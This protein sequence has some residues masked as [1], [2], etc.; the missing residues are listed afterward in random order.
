MTL[1][2]PPQFGQMNIAAVDEDIAN[3]EFNALRND[4]LKASNE[5][6]AGAR[7]AEGQFEVG[8]FLEEIGTGYLE[9]LE[10]DPNAY[11]DSMSMLM[12]EFKSRGIPT[13]RMPAAGTSTKQLKKDFVKM[14]E[15]GRIAQAG[16]K[17]KQPV[18]YTQ[19]VKGVNAETG[20]TEWHR[21]DST[22]ALNPT[23]I[24]VPESDP[25]VSVVNEAEGA[26]MTAEQ[27]ALARTRVAAFDEINKASITAGETMSTIETMRNIDFEGGP[28][29]DL[30]N[31]FRKFMMAIGGSDLVD[32]DKVVNADAFTA[33]AFD[34]FLRIMA[35]QKGPQTDNDFRRIQ[36]TFAD[37][38]DPKLLR[39]FLLDS[40]YAHAARKQEM[41]QF[42]HDILERDGTLK[43]ADREWSAYKQVTPLLSDTIRDPQTGL[44]VFYINFQQRMKAAN[45]QAS[46][47]QI[48]QKW[49]ELTQGQ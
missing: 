32:V 49:R 20:E 11:R 34:E 27:Q 19:P 33:L 40:T 13:D 9:R 29:T 4:A 26:G 45:P 38:N 21:P 10:S 2:L 44:P 31:N 42:Y 14:V 28:G 23:G 12:E 7:E 8:R 22:G 5:Y 37:A 39:T 24:G 43:N 15:M 1:Q 36:R 17:E 35:T 25:L 48:L 46:Q 16:L 30:K 18:T 3:N 6:T 47:E 41:A